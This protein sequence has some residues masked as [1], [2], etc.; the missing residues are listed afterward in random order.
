MQAKIYPIY[1][2]LDV[3][4]S[5]RRKTSNGQRLIDLSSKIP[6]ALFSLYEEHNSLA[7]NL[8]IALVTFNDTAS[9]VQPLSP[10]NSLSELTGLEASGRT[11]YSSAFEFLHSTISKD[12]SDDQGRLYKRPLV[13][14]ATDGGPNDPPSVR[15]LAFR[16][17]VP[18]DKKAGKP[19]F[20]LGK[21]I[22]NVAIFAFGLPTNPGERALHV[23]EMKKYVT[24]DEYFYLADEAK[25]LYEQFESVVTYIA[26]TVWESMFAD[27][28]KE[29]QDDEW[30]IMMSKLNSGEGDLPI[31]SS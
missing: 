29:I 7:S 22:P 25:D 1:I 18:L 14:V 2:L 4:D 26:E 19:E 12:M 5:M 30:E 9:L 21:H 16:T 24:K 13:I 31:F 27:Q 28:Q 20:S 23:R 17:L 10:I 6:E 11:S 3:S 8:S 15:E